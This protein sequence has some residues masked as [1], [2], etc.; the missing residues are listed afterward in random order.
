[1]K[2]KKSKISKP[3]VHTTFPFTP[4]QRDTLSNALDFLMNCE[5][6]SFDQA[7]ISHDCAFE[8]AEKLD[9]NEYTLTRG[10]VRASAAAVDNAI[11]ALSNSNYDFSSIE[12]DFPGLISELRSSLTTLEYLSLLLNEAVTDLRK[13]K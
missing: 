8:T 3:I 2:P 13:I 10:E 1:M 4:Q 7:K 11:Q 6:F 5:D 9:D 12:E